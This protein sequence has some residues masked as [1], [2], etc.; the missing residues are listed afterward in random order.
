MAE[1]YLRAQEAG[2]WRDHRRSD[3]DSPAMSQQVEQ[4]SLYSRPLSREGSFGTVGGGA[5]HAA[6]M[7]S[8][9]KT[10]G[11]RAVQRFMSGQRS[12]TTESNEVVS[13]QVGTKA[14]QRFPFPFIPQGD[15]GSEAPADPE[16]GILDKMFGLNP[17]KTFI[18]SGLDGLYGENSPGKIKEGDSTL[19]KLGRATYSVGVS[20][21]IPFI[22]SG[23]EMLDVI[24]HPSHFLTGPFSHPP[25]RDDPGTFIPGNDGVPF[26]PDDQQF[27]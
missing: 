17:H 8:A 3:A 4:T 26:V 6:T 18:E 22:V 19:T 13:K 24:N 25:N 10:Y 23:G 5:I 7:Q 2:K 15:L 11:N 14:V 21:A 16:A 9:Q 20:P 27:G 12:A 1:E